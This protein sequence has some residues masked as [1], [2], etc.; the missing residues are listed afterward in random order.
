MSNRLAGETSPY[1]L[2]HKD[3]P[4]DWYPWSEETLERAREEDKPILLSIGYS[5][6]HWCHVMAHE[7]FENTQIAALMNQNFIN[8]KV[9]REERPDLDSI[10]MAAVQTMTGSGGWPLTV[11]LTPDGK[12]FY[13]GTYFP[14]EDRHG[15]PGLTKILNF[16]ADAYKHHRD[17]ILQTTDKLSSILSQ[18]VENKDSTGPLTADILENALS[19]LKN[20]Y[21]HINGGFGSA[22]KFPQPNVLDFLLTYF[23]YS[24]DEEAL[25]MV[26]LT[27]KKMARGGIFDQIGGGFHRYSTDA[28]WLIPHFEKMLYDNAL[29]SLVY[30]HM[31][32]ITKEQ[33]YRNISERTLDYVLREM[34][35]PRGGFYS[36]QDADS[37]G[38][39][40]DYYTW[41]ANEIAQVI[42]EKDYDQLSRYYG[43]TSHGNFEGK[44]IPYVTN[45][46]GSETPYIV[47]KSRTALLKRREQRARP[48][49][50]EKILAAWNGLMLSSLAEAARTFNRED[51]LQ[52][53]IANGDF[54]CNFMIADGYLMHVYKDGE[55][56][57][58]GYLQDYALVIEGLL[59]LHQATFQGKWLKHAI[60]LTDIMIE[61]FWD[62]YVGTWYDNGK[63]HEKL[64]IRPR[65][66][67]DDVMP[68]G[69][70]AAAMILLKL[71]L[72][73][74]ND[75]FQDIALKSLNSVA[76]AMSQYPGGYSNWLCALSLYL[77]KPKQ[78]IIVGP[79]DNPATL[80]LQNALY[81]TLIPDKVV[82]SYDPGDS[83][84]TASLKFLENKQMLNG[85]PTAYVCQEYS[86]KTPVT[87]AASLADQ[88]Q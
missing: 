59:S 17:E 32:Q 24:K 46:T 60:S 62:E 1:L 74:N 54:L 28:I 19:N 26:K 22:P 9:D 34:R 79:G 50:D 76:G 42:G 4:V 70:S 21:E 2:Q 31:Y 44:N 72:L 48:G 43:I 55:A 12:P 41:S 5:S 49:R 45:G 83:A 11:F 15:M 86:C 38:I 47:E 40:G 57:I 23:L 39:E 3:N 75:H 29:L 61:Q 63:R 6:C 80:D 65:N 58:D 67:S 56:R 20:S 18:I 14:P 68:C 33:F 77:T 66:V 13:G 27:L 10:Y 78:I 87:D 25:E 36:S 7:S 82:V 88:L 37:N 64:F 16:I 71:A 84:L 81:N 52:A 53:A 8:I 85:Q 35:D 30:L 73:T 69:S 51:Y